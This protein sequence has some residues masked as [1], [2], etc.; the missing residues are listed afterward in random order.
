MKLMFRKFKVLF[1]AVFLLQNS[2]L[3]AQKLQDGRLNEVSGLVV[4]SK[5]DEL[6]WVHNDSGDDGRI[7]LINKKGA[8]QAVYIFAKEV[9]DCEAIDRKS[10]R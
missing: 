2:Y 10:T 6:I 8:T 3:F 1:V 5:S 9:R 7:F 4:S